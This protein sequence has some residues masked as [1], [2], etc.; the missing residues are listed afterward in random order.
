LVRR[1][2]HDEYGEDEVMGEAPEIDV[3]QIMERIR[4]NIR[5]RRSAGKGGP[6]ESHVSPFDEGSAEADLASLHS[7]YDIRDV[8]FVS[9]RPLIGPF[10]VAVK[11]AVRKL[12]TP[13]LERQVAYNAASARVT[14]YIKDWVDTLFRQQAALDRNQAL[15]RDEFQAQLRHETQALRQGVLAAESRVAAQAQEAMA[16][17]ALLRDE[18][19]AQLRHETQALRQEQAQLRHE[20]Q[21]RDDMIALQARLTEDL[22]RQSETVQVLR[23]SGG[24]T[25]ERVSRAERKLRRIIHAMEIGRPQDGTLRANVSEEEPAPPGPALEPGFDYAGFAERFRGSEEEIKERQRAYVQYFEGRDNILD[26]GCGRGEFLELLRERGLKARG[27]DLDLDMILLCREKGLDVVMDDAFAYLGVLPDDSVG[28]VFASQVIE[29]LHP[30]RIIE[31]TR[32]CYRKLAPGGVLIF[33]TP[34]PKCLMVFADSFYKD[35]SHLQPAHPDTMQFLFEATGFHRVELTFLCPVDP[36]MRIPFLQGPG[37]DIER[38]NQGIERLNSLLF[39][40]QDYAV[41]GRKDGA[42]ARQDIA[43]L[44]PDS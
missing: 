14:T 15:L 8:S 33:E 7:G 4:E 26:I 37:P 44:G 10:V 32:L 36:F 34:N 18:F 22:A 42:G 25:R 35:P 1:R 3:E 38:F 27:L 13:I 23:Q 11:R 21:A 43:S 19:Q 39:G 40:F 24:A 16:A 20:T 17:Q 31:L 29:H 5:R 28:G 6:S 9:H 30:A 12:L 41:I 2:T